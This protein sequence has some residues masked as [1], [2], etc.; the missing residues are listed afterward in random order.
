MKKFLRAMILAAL[1]AVC[2]V[3]AYASSSE[4]EG[5]PV[6]VNNWD[7]PAVFAAGKDW[8]ITTWYLYAGDGSVLG[9]I[10]NRTVMELSKQHPT[11][12]IQWETWLAEAF[13]EYRQINGTVRTGEGSIVQETE[14]VKPQPPKLGPPEEKEPVIE[15]A[16]PAAEPEQPD[17]EALA[18]EVIRRTNAE[19]EKHGLG[20]LITDEAL[21]ELAMIRAEEVSYKYS[22]ERPDGSRVVHLGYGENVGAKATPKKQ[23]SSWMSSEGHRENILLDWYSS[24]GVG[25]YQADD[26]STYW[27]QVFAP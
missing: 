8:P 6:T 22:H 1:F 15:A 25:Y 24:I 26:G 7:T 21:M 14:P 4:L 23:V 20:P 13:N 16:P 5:Y 2:T 18:L 19:R 17:A 12:S 10:P 3:T 11:G 9:S 27:V